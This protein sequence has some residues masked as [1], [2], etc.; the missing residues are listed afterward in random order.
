MNNSTVCLA[1][2]TVCNGTSCVVPEEDFNT[3]LSV[4]LSTVLTI[5]LSLVMFSMGCN[6]ETKKFLGHVKRPWGIC[7]GFLCQFG[8]MPLTG[9]VL[10][11]TFDILPIQ[12]VVVLI[13]G[14]C[15]GGTTSNILAYWADGDMDLSISMT[16]CSTLLALGMMPLCL[17]IYTKMWVDSGKIIIPYDKIGISLVALVVPVS[18]GMFVNHRWPHK[19]KIILKIGSITGALF[20]VFIAVAGG[21]L[22]QSAWI[23]EPKLWIIGTIFPLA[24]YSL[25]F[26]LARIAGQSWH[27]CRTVALET[28]MQ[29][30]QLCSTIVQ[31][32]FTTEELNLI[33]TFPLIYS[34][35]QLIIAAIFL[36]L[37]VAYKKYYRKDNMELPEG[38]GNEPVPESSFQK[39]NEGF[40]PDEKHTPADQKEKF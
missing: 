9:F 20:I 8:I 27:R 24:G 10:S 22:Y 39:V 26:F 19:A 11:V 36:A 32:S 6:V 25:G 2:A 14:C 30:A 40:Q 13:M 5:L 15:P 7:V 34:I 28:G 33:F 31:L 4:V 21:V 35:F 1:N 18:I 17:L 23:I 16:T 38:K 3:T 12:A 37:Y 29:N